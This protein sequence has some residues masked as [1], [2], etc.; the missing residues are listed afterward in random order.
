M[1]GSC[2]EGASRQAKSRWGCGQKRCGAILPPPGAQDIIAE[3]AAELAEGR[4]AARRE[5]HNRG[6]L[7]SMLSNSA[8]RAQQVGVLTPGLQCMLAFHPG[9]LAGVSHS[10]VSSSWR[11]VE[12]SL[13][14]ESKGISSRRGLTLVNLHASTPPHCFE[15]A[16]HTVDVLLQQGKKMEE[17]EK[18]KKAKEEGREKAQWRGAAGSHSGADT[19][20]LYHEF[21]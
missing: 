10:L 12:N 9:N 19:Y 3:L 6:M 7:L 11:P 17:V 4:E 1:K 21:K 5:L 13:K 2:R 15:T 18:G 8:K 14:R 16:H 20:S